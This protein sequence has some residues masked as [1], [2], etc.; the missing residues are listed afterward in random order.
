MSLSSSRPAPKS[1]RFRR[2]RGRM[3]WLAAGAGTLALLAIVLLVLRGGGEADPWR[4][5]TVSRGEIVQSVSA[6]GALEA[7]VTVQ[8]GS[9]LS[10][11]VTEVLV[12]FNDR[13][14]RGQPLAILDPQTYESRIEQARAAVAAADAQVAQQQAGLAQAQ[15][16]V[17]L[18]QAEF[19]RQK[20]L[21]DRGIAAQAALDAAQAQLTTAEAGVRTARAQIRSAG[22]GVAQ[23][24]AALRANQVERGRTVI[25]SPVD[26]VII[27]RQ[28]EPGQTVASGLN[29]AVL[30]TVAQDLSRL[31]AEVLVDE[32]DIGRVRE[33][34]PVRFTVDAFPEDSFTGV[35]T[36]VRKLPQTESNVVA[37]TVAVEADNPGEK[38]LPGMTAN[39]DIILDRRA[40]VLRVPSAALRFTP[41]GMEGQSARGGGSSAPVPGMGGG[42]RRRRPGQG[43]MGAAIMEE[44]DLDPAQRAR[45]EPIL[46][47]A[48][49]GGGGAQ[50]GQRGARRAARAA[51][52][53]S[54]FDQ[55]RPL[56]RPDQQ[57]QL[58]TLRARF[59]G[60]GQRGVVWVLRDGEPVQVPVRI[61]ASDGAFTEIISG[62][63]QAGDEVIVGGGPRPDPSDQ[64]QGRGG[65]RVRM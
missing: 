38:L 34:Q 64:P 54:A 45:V 44:L 7:L 5:E 12:D 53:N 39:A 15:A 35:V 37:Y 33:G 55:I 1:L 36:Q 52:L 48:L 20:F 61:G 22:A 30:F 40:D 62:E 56:L 2:P 11:Q 31:Q 3:L 23:Q 25:R 9:Q 57:T 26:G 50:N 17:E 51:A 21:F 32:A 63:L 58:E 49:T 29:V 47:S 4:T 8:V 27:D 10:G 28:I 59:A 14:V 13:V 24:Q 43:D 65:V 46:R 6:S 60:G 16:N 19:N 42:Q 41:A 18:A